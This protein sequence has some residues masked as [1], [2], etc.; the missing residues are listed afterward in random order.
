MWLVRWLGTVGLFMLVVS[1][2]SVGWQ[3]WMVL[4]FGGVMFELALVVLSGV[5][6]L[7]GDGVDVM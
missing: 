4:I 6:A 7:A 5:L 2:V 1:S 3:W